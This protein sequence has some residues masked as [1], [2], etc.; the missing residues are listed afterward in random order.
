MLKLPS[1]AAKTEEDPVIAE[2]DV[3]ITPSPAEQLYL[4]QYPIRNR[5]QPYNERNAAVP[6]E[7]RIKPRS[8]F[9]EMDVDMN[10]THNFN[11]AQGLA[12]GK[13][14]Q[15]AQTA[16]MSSFGAA[17]GFG[18][19]SI[20]R[21]SRGQRGGD[22]MDQYDQGDVERFDVALR[23]KQVFHKQTLGGQ[24]LKRDEGTP[25]YMLGAF[26]GGLSFT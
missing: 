25:N 13:A 9:L 1:T 10:T 8:G 14:M 11:K 16:G 2:Y 15:K 18:Q 5:A 19:G 4:L 12:W 7:M 22:P 24:I 17:A 3:Y 23:R 21:P 20:Q 6:V 26:R